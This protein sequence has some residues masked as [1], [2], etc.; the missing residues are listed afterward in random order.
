MH[1]EIDSHS[2]R[3]HFLRSNAR[4]CGVHA[5]DGHVCVIDRGTRALVKVYLLHNL[6]GPVAIKILECDK[7]NNELHKELHIMKVRKTSQQK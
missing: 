2:H 5:Y 1:I 4:V 3:R 6:L 7:S